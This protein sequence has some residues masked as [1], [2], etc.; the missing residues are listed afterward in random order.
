MEELKA[1]TNQKNISSQ[2][3]LKKLG[4]LITGKTVLPKEDDEL[5][6]FELKK[7]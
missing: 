3:L 1:I 6:L 7:K 5:F 2:A 4:F